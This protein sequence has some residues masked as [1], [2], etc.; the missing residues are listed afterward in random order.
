MTDKELIEAI[1]TWAWDKVR[2]KGEAMDGL[3]GSIQFL[4]SAL[5]TREFLRKVCELDILESGIPKDIKLKL[6]TFWGGDEEEGE[7]VDD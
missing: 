1:K 3:A 5:T 7:L 4:D 6:S 2:E